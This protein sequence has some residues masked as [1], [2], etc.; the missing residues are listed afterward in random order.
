MSIVRARTTV[1]LALRD[2]EVLLIFSLL[3]VNC[4]QRI[5]LNSDSS[6][7]AY[8]QWWRQWNQICGACAVAMELG[9]EC[10]SIWRA[11]APGQ[12][13]DTSTVMSMQYI[14]A[15]VASGEPVSRIC[16]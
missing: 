6:L 12:D 14:V 1:I 5:P 9:L 10:G 15:Y 16:A 3:E 7:W 13:T 8:W 4:G 2:A 11:S